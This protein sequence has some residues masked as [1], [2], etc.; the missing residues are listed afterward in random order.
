MTGFGIIILIVC[1]VVAA[2]AIGAYLTKDQKSLAEMT[3]EY[4]DN[5]KVEQPKNEKFQPRKVTVVEKETE[6]VAQELYNKDLRP[7]VAKKA[8][9]E[10]KAEE[11]KKETK[12]EFPIDKPKKKKKYYP[13]KK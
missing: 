12:S 2:G 10:E 8:S 5:E 3:K 9:K 7:I 6:A 11:V 13:K 1:V 4:Y